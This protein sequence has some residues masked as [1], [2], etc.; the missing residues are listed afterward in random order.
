MNEIKFEYL[1]TY[2]DRATTKVVKTLSEI[3]Q[4]V[5]GFGDV[6][7]AHVNKVKEIHLTKI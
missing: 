1:V 2:E 7:S 6:L 3:E 5:M 4:G